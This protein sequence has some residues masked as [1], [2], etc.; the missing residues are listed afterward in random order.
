MKQYLIASPGQLYLVLTKHLEEFSAEPACLEFKESRVDFGKA[1]AYHD[2]LMLF[3]AKVKIH[4]H[5]FFDITSSMLALASALPPE[6]VALGRH[7]NVCL[8]TDQRMVAGTATD[9]TITGRQALAVEDKIYAFLAANSTL[10]TEEIRRMHLEERFVTAE[11]AIAH[12]WAGGY[13]H[14]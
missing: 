11:Q 13:I 3:T 8:F 1:L 9:I 2:V 4:L 10:S 5:F 12:N 14:V 7:V 6:Q